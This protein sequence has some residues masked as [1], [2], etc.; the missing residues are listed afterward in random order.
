MQK[1]YYTA[2][3]WQNRELLER[4]TAAGSEPG[5]AP[6]G[7]GGSFDPSQKRKSHTRVC[8]QPPARLSF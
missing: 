5:P 4:R 6:P 3:V 2:L 8:G 7:A 1:A